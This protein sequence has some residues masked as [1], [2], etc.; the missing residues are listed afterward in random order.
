MD[1]DPA[2]QRMRP[3][4][5]EGIRRSPWAPL[6]DAPLPKA[7][8]WVA[9]GSVLRGAIY[10]SPPGFRPLLLDLVP[11]RRRQHDRRRSS[12]GSM[13]APS[14]PA[15]GRC[16]PT[17]LARGRLF[18]RVPK[19]GIALAA[20]DYRLSGEA[21]FPAQLHD[22]KAAIRWLRSRQCRARDRPRPDRRLGRVG[23]RAPGG[24]GSRH[25]R[26]R[27]ARGR[28]RR[29]GPS[30]AVAAAVDWY[31]PTDFAAMDRDAPEDSAMCHDAPGSPESLLIGA[32]VQARPD[33]VARANP[34]AWVFAGAHR[35]SRSSTGPA[36]ASCRSDRA[37]G[38]SMRSAR[39]VQT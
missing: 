21:L 30:S 25:G 13:A 26:C 6:H 32:P 34:C 3:E 14:S 23:R 39:M 2:P 38:W 29:H 19:A 33:L 15:A 8:D 37:S 12:C 18:E 27:G 31:G 9:G 35:R 28:D 11:R 24:D 36:T 17:L 5:P 22:V 7:D 20:I 1:S 10:A 16:C 4:P